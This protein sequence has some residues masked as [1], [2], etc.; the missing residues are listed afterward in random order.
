M[1]YNKTKYFLI[2]Q[3]QT[4]VELFENAEFITTPTI[5]F[6]PQFHPC[7]LA[8]NLNKPGHFVEHLTGVLKVTPRREELILG[9][10]KESRDWLQL[11]SSCLRKSAWICQR[12]LIHARCWIK[13]SMRSS[14]LDCLQKLQCR[15]FFFFFNL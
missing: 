12:F 3:F 13:E 1:Y 4:S 6:Y 7:H 14:N 8:Q 9:L 15:I 5:R 11:V 2:I 10:W